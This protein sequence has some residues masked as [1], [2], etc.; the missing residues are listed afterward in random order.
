[1]SLRW[2]GISISTTLSITQYDGCFEWSSTTKGCVLSKPPDW[3]SF[4]SYGGTW[5][6]DLCLDLRN[7]PWLRSDPPSPP[8]LLHAQLRC[9]K[10]PLSFSLW[11]KM[12]ADW[13]MTH[14]N[15]LSQNYTEN[16]K[17]KGGWHD[18][19]ITNVAKKQRSQFSCPGIHFVLF[20]GFFPQ[21]PNTFL[22]LWRDEQ[23]EG[24][25]M[26][27]WIE[28]CKPELNF[29]ARWGRHAQ[30]RSRPN[31][32]LLSQLCLLL[33]PPVFFSQYHFFSDCIF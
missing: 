26:S 12:I 4:N 18:S 7:L 13:C 31:R 20:W 11:K 29:A 23:A 8:L 2:G 21:T 16:L 10:H 30:N 9:A 6:V 25:G 27:R 17:K 14:G 3:F 32:I 19:C 5:F 1:M 24:S 28:H 33:S 15:F 22:M